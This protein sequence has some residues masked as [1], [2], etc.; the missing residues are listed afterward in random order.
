[1]GLPP[2]LI[3][4][5]TS[6]F[7]KIWTDKGSGA[8]QDGAFYRP[9]TQYF[10]VG[11]Y[12]QG[13]YDP[14]VGQVIT[15][16]VEN[17]DPNNP[18]LKA[19]QGFSQVYNDKGS[20]SDK[21]GSIWFPVAPDGYTTIGYVSQGGYST[22]SIPNLM[23]VRTDL[24]VRASIGNEIWSDKGSHGDEDVAVYAIVPPPSIDAPFGMFY[25]QSNYNQP[26]GEVF[27]VNGTVGGGTLTTPHGDVRIVRKF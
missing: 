9:Q 27:A 6:N 7:T 22:P 18:L 10:I 25:A 11:D 19:P 26:T 13:N 15:L 24:V 1:M 14:P 3:M 2:T 5:S 23:C 20:G 21:D 4:S 8:D 17:D 12:C 16:Q